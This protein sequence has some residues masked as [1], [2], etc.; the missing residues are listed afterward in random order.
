MASNDSK[1]TGS[2]PDLYDRYMV[3]MLFEPYARDTVERLAAEPVNDVLE[4]AA[5]TGVVTRVLAGRLSKARIVATDL[6][7]P[8]LDHAR[9]RQGDLGGVTF[10]QADALALPFADASFDAVVCQFGVMFFPDRVQGYR[11]A[12][13]VVRPGGRYLFNAWGC[14]ADNDFVGVAT[15]ALA[16]LYP[17]DPPR[18]ME[19][20][21][22]GYHDA[23]KIR[24]DVMAA[25]FADVAIETVDATSRAA[26]AHDAATGYCQ[27]SPLRGE[28]EALD[29]QGLARA[30]AHVAAAIA[31]RF[32]DGPIEG[33]ISALVIT[34]TR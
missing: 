30:T 28:I 9:A 25:G 20:V 2:I 23:G 16:E 24:D 32:G 26:S 22:H 3:P 34:A 21:P 7:Q 6:N 11:E 14:V 1:F 27:G 12:R 8:M 13:R 29:P 18:F 10:R 33:R 15:R 5:G 31:H 4:V 17:K 19:R